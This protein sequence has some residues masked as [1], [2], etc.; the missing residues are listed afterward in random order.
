MKRL[1]LAVTLGVTLA[2]TGCAS[3]QPPVEVSVPVSVPCVAELPPY[4]ELKAPG[5]WGTNVF[6][7]VRALLIDRKLLVAHVEEL[8]AILEGCKQ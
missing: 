3:L 5:A 2:V 8:R 7:R 1:T 6:E 4:P